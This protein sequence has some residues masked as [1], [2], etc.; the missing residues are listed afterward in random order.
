MRPA[1]ICGLLWFGLP[2]WLGLAELP[3]RHR[4][5]LARRSVLTAGVLREDAAGLGLEHDYRFLREVAALLRPADTLLLFRDFA[6]RAQPDVAIPLLSGGW[7]GATEIVWTDL[8]GPGAAGEVIGPVIDG[9]RR[10]PSEIA[11]LLGRSTVA[12]AWD[13]AWPL[14]AGRTLL[15]RGVRW[16]ALRL[17]D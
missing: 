2:L 5:A 6:L 4:E 10:R 8:P 15:D 7:S 9:L 3:P 13:S 17:R 12:V 14:P 16:R 1:Q 11:D